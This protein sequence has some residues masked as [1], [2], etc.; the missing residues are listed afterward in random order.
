MNKKTKKFT[1]LI[2]SAVVVFASLFVTAAPYLGI[3]GVPTWKDIF[4]N[5]GVNE[6]NDPGDM[7]LSI[8][9]I[10]VGQGDCIFVKS[11]DGNILIDAGEKGNESVIN[12]YL[13]SLKVTNIDYVVATHPHS[14]HIGGLPGV[15]DEFEIENIIMPRLPKSITPTTKTY[16]NLLD[17]AAGSGAKIIAAKPGAQYNL[18]GLT[19]TVLGPIKTDGDL[20]NMSV[21]TRITYGGKSFVFMGDAETDEENDILAS[22]DK[23]DSDVIKIGHHGSSSS[24]GDELLKAVTPD[25]AVIMCGEG[26]SYKH[27]H[28]ETV[29]KL[30]Y[31]DIETYRTD[32]MG[33]VIISTDGSEIYYEILNRQD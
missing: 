17:S 2:L 31:L 3:D 26:N 20:N 19:M 6:E 1:A 13:G 21:V 32:L 9:F 4:E 33:T 27:P 7:P 28:V 24:T 23:L 25:V 8:H 16:E 18:G 12:D 22:G 5:T 10:N 29:K 30:D 14:D 11:D 15:I